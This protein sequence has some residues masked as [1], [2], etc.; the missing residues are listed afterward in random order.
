MS[1]LFYFYHFQLS[2]PDFKEIWQVCYDKISSHVSLSFYLEEL[3][4][5]QLLEAL[6]V[7]HQPRILPRL[8]PRLKHRSEGSCQNSNYK[9]TAT[10]KEELGEAPNT[11]HSHRS[12]PNR[13]IASH[14]ASSPVSPALPV[15]P[16]AGRM[17]PRLTHAT[18]GRATKSRARL[19]QAA[20][21]VGPS[22]TLPARRS[23]RPRAH[24]PHAPSLLWALVI[25]RSQLA[26]CSFSRPMI[27]RLRSRREMWRPWKETAPYFS[28]DENL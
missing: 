10:T 7:A 23:P 20:A 19:P 26:A 25:C 3:R 15:P 11:S 1:H 22:A 12:W 24:H 16:H 4:K 6:Y 18:W 13:I 2:P 28:A 8:A 17:G 9:R 27:C 5:A 21:A 14:P